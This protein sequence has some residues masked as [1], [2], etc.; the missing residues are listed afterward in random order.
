VKKLLNRLGLLLS[1][2]LLWLL[3]LVAWIL[4]PL[5][6]GPL[7]AHDQYPAHGEHRARSTMTILAW[8]SGVAVQIAVQIVSDSRASG[9]RRDGR[10]HRRQS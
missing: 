9:V 5:H 4:S 10:Q 8:R 6:P 7:A 3:R 2:S 1:D